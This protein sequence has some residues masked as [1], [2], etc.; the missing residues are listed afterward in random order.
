M[1]RILTAK[2]LG[3]R[4][5]YDGLQGLTMIHACLEGVELFFELFYGK[6][7]NYDSY[8]MNFL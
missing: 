2:G 8:F 5:D 4:V 6:G 3:F 7:P 1:V